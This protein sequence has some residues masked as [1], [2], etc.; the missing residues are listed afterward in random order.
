MFRCATAFVSLLAVLAVAQSADAQYLGRNKVRYNQFDFRVLQTEHF[1]IYYYADEEAATTHAARMAE[2]WYAR[3]STLFNHTFSRRQPLVLYASHPDFTQTNVT[4]A[5]PGEGTGG[6]TERTKSRIAMP[7][8][9]GLG[10]TDHVLGHEIAH[11]FQIDIVKRAGLDAF[12]L[13][14]WFIE[15]MA[16]YLSVGADDPHTA[17]WLRDAAAHDRLPTIA[18]LHDPG[19]SPYRHGH[20]FWSF[21]TNRFGDKVLGPILRSK[22]RNIPRRLEAATGINPWREWA[23]IELAGENGSYELPR[24]RDEYAGLIVSLARQEHPDTSVFDDP[25]IVWRLEKAHHIGLIVRSPSPSRVDELLG[26]YVARA[27]R[28]FHAAAPPQDHPSE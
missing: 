26:K 2:R 21:V 1:D 3:F 10:A 13:P 12:A 14:G 17:M 19:F 28:D 15:G 6:L 27:L 20:A 24:A 5:T 16:E 25:E 22:V 8:A 18:T 4:P 11:A 7:F 9:A 23:K